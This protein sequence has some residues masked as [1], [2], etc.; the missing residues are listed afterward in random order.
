MSSYLKMVTN[1]SLALAQSLAQ[2][3]SAGAMNSDVTMTRPEDGSY[4]DQA[5]AY[6]PPTG[7]PYY[8]G[9]AGITPADGPIVMDLGD[10]P[11][12]YSSI[13]WMLP[14]GAPLPRI[15]DQIKIIANPGSV[16]LVG[17]MFRVTN[18]KVGGRLVAST[19]GS[20]TGVAPSKQW[21]T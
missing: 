9:E 2:A 12:Y 11:A 7:L 10:E 4:D 18:V 20:A 21:S 16:H 17:R 3:V 13:S 15:D 5:R 14:V 6:V 8:L 1:R 19:S